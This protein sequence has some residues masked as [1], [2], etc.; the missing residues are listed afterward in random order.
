MNIGKKFRQVLYKTLSF[1]QYM[2]VLSRFY[3]FFYRSGMLKNNPKF[4]YP[5][6]LKNIIKKGNV[7]IDIG[8]N[9]GYYTCLFAACVGSNGKI[10]AI[11]PVEPVL[12]ILK[13]NTKKYPWVEILPYALGRENKIIQ[14]G[15]DSLKSKGYIASGSHFV[16]DSSNPEAVENPETVFRAEM[17]KGSELFSGFV[18][19]DF[20]KCDVEGYEIVIIPEIKDV[21]KQFQPTVLI[22]TGKENRLKIISIM[23]EMGYEALV[24]EN[25]KLRPLLPEDSADILF[26]HHDKM[27]LA[28]PYFQL[29]KL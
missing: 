9:L 4:Q 17:R 26:V 14:L 19:I 15:N 28:E 2:S 12:N 5:Y 7:V 6:F 10:Y 25:K 8:A 20:I 22:E 27:T 11:E 1:E 21:I 13:K 16:M 18:K 24:V 29:K 3:F 23:T